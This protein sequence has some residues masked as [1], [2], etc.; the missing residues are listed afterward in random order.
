VSRRESVVAKKRESG[1]SALLAEDRIDI[2]PTVGQAVAL[3]AAGL[4][5]H[6]RTGSYVASFVKPVSKE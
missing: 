4:G 5:L 1:R 2:A 3:V 6:A